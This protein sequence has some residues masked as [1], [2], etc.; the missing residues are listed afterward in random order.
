MQVTRIIAI[1]HGETAW[2]VGTRL[3]GH[4][5][6][7]LNETGLWQAGRVAHAL[8]D[9]SIDAIYASDLLRAW[10]TA[11]AIA[12]SC[13][14]SLT[15]HQGLRERGFGEFEGKTYAEI[16]ATWPEM[17]EQW[18]KREPHWAPPGGESLATLRERVLNTA[19]A[20]AQQHLGGQ[21]VLVAH[22][23]VMDILYRLATGQE[24]QAPRAWNLGNAAINRLLWT[25][26]GFTLV[27]W[28][29]TR[30]LE[31]SNLDEGST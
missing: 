23:G 24:L 26:E 10:Q 3:Q 9:E 1:R 30:H 18:R 17:S 31:S 25:P 11:S 7:A 4:L 29:D 6:I 13:Q 27:G 2:N 22:G 5:D 20:L 28:A 15:A 16:E 19:S 12:H 8:A 21:M 14:C